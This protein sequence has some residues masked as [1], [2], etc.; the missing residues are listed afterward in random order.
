MQMFWCGFFVCMLL[1]RLPPSLREV[2]SSLW[3]EDGG[4]LLLRS[5]L[6]TP[7][8]LGNVKDEGLSQSGLR[9]LS[10]RSPATGRTRPLGTPPFMASYA[11]RAD[12]FRAFQS[13]R[14]E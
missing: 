3:R 7:P 1:L 8:T 9:S 6:E 10:L 13:R 2:D 14:P 11:C 12:S 5:F 4:S